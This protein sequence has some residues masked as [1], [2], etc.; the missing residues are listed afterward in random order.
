MKALSVIDRVI[1]VVYTLT[2]S[3]VCIILVAVALGWQDPLRFMD[4]APL[5][6]AGR[7][8]MAVVGLSLLLVN[9][10]LA[11]VAFLGGWRRK[12]IIH[13][14]P[15]GRVRISLSAVEG[16]VARLVR[17]HSGVKEARSA[18]RLTPEGISVYVRSTVGPE[19]EI[20]RL[21]DELQQAIK[22]QVRQVVGVSVE[23]VAIDID[24][25]SPRPTR[26]SRV[27]R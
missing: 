26:V 9:I 10:R 23:R 17:A 19:V 16:L 3:L 14:L 15:M 25:I 22:S 8:T 12:Q 5:S 18:V 20:S 27:D 11:A 1:L 24:H 7:L 21:S 13:D 4:R 6:V 2:L